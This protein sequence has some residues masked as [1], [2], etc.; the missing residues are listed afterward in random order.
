MELA[1][2]LPSYTSDI[3]LVSRNPS[4]ITGEEELV[5]ADLMKAEGAD[6][7]IAGSEIVYLTA[8]LPYRKAIW[9]EAWPV[10]MGN[11]LEACKRHGSKLVFFDNV[12]PYGKVDGWMTEDLPFQP[13]SAKGEA[14]AVIDKM[15]MESVEKGEVEAILARAADFYGPSPLAYL[16]LLVFERLAN[17]KKHSISSVLNS[18]IHLPTLLMPPE[19]QPYWE[20]MR[21][22]LIR[23]GTCQQI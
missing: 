20:I 17:G 10:L 23:P 1:N 22:P 6:A 13:A 15:V 16:H 4:Q 7:A 2:I 14:R 3:R 12:Y 5:S 9:K 19:E 21:M 18:G 8:G 11:V